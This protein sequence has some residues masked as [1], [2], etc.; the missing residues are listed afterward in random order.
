MPRGPQRILIIPMVGVRVEVGMSVEL[1]IKEIVSAGT[2]SV[3][4]ENITSGVVL[5]FDA[6][7]Q[8]CSLCI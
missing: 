8:F 5:K 6:V 4:P 1:R 7:L 3:V 2:R